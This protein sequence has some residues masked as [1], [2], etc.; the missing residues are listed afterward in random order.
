PANGSARKPR[1][2]SRRARP[3]PSGQ[4]GRARN[5]LKAATPP[6]PAPIVSCAPAAAAARTRWTPRAARSHVL[7]AVDVDLRP[8]HVGRGFRAK[9]INDLDDLVGR[10]EL[11]HGNLRDDLLGA[12]RENRG[13]DLAWR[14]GVDADPERTEIGRHLARER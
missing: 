11:M 5:R 8:V 6:K 9:H 13:V 10:A 14:D 3:R 2:S 1:L 4:A 7:T 12:G